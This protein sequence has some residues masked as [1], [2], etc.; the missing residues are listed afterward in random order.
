MSNK[1]QLYVASGRP[2]LQP[3]GDL[4]DWHEPIPHSPPART[5]WPAVMSLAIAVAMWGMLLDYIVVGA[6]VL[7]FVIACAGWIGD[8]LRE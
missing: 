1:D 4:T 2:S 5:F 7:L 6:A 8:L 3:S